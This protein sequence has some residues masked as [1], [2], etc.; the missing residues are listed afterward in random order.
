MKKLILWVALFT[1]MAFVSGVMAQQPKPATAP[2]K[3]ATPEPSKTTAAK[4]EKF[5]GVVEKVDEL[6]KAV[7]VKGNKAVN[8]FSTDDKTK[9]TK[10]KETLTLSDLKGG[11]NVSIEYKKD[12][13]KLVASAIKVATPKAAPKKEEPKK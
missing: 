5:S 4:V 6:A 1:V 11:M 8:T 9:I 2:E 7:V 3:T 10:G 12:G 13:D